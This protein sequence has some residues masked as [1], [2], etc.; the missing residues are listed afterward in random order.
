MVSRLPGSVEKRG[1]EALF[2]PFVKLPFLALLVVF[3]CNAVHYTTTF[4]WLRPIA[5]VRIQKITKKMLYD[6]VLMI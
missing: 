6:F 2:S 5:P 4:Y 1:Q 3:T